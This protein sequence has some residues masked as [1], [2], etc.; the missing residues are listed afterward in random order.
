MYLLIDEKFI[1]IICLDASLD[2]DSLQFGT[3]LKYLLV[4]L[5]KLTLRQL[6]IENQL[7]NISSLL[8]LFPQSLKFLRTLHISGSG[9]S[10]LAHLTTTEAYIRI[11]ILVILVCLELKAGLKWMI[12]RFLSALLPELVEVLSEGV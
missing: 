7:H 11:P 1:V 10:G 8:K 5:D 3:G 2:S 4:S 6:P 9:L 12:A